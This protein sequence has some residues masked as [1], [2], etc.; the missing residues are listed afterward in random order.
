MGG[1][2]VGG[3]LGAGDL[4]AAPVFGDDDGV[5]WVVVVVADLDGEVDAKA[6]HL[7][8]E[9]GDV[10]YRLV[11]D[12]GDAVV[13]EEHL[14]A[15]GTILE[16]GGAFEK[17]AVEGGG[18]DK[19]AVR[20]AAGVG[21]AGPASLLDGFRGGAGSPQHDDRDRCGGNQTRSKTSGLHRRAE[22][23]MDGRGE[24]GAT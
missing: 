13:E 24:H 23:E 9:A 19:T 6:A 15:G 16:A 5:G 4:E 17:A 22:L 18:V 2:G 14:G 12:P 3:R 11:G 7:I 21:E 10:L 8:G 1:R 20:D